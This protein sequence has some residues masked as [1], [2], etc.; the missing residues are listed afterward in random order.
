MYFRQALGTLKWKLWVFWNM[1]QQ[2]G[3][4]IA[5]GIRYRAIPVQ[6]PY[7]L[8][9]NRYKIEVL[10][11]HMVTTH[12]IMIFLTGQ[13]TTDKLYI[14][15]LSKSFSRFF[16][17]SKQVDVYIVQLH[18]YKHSLLLSFKLS[19][20]DLIIYICFCMVFNVEINT[21]LIKNIVLSF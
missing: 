20:F 4:R 16:F 6:W 7:M 5:T 10:H 3:S 9:P 17:I 19:I 11:W 12:N 8:E 2:P 18:Y 14:Y 13:K 15:S 1:P 21:M